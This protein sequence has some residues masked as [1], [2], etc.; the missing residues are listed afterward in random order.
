MSRKKKDNRLKVT[1]RKC[2]KE[3]VYISIDDT[4]ITWV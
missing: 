2:L 3:K 1:I 4:L